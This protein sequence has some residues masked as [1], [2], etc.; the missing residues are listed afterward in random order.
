MSKTSIDSPSVSIVIPAYNEEE[1]IKIVLSD[2]IPLAEK[3]NWEIVVVDDFSS[4]ETSAAVEVFKKKYNQLQLIRN[5]YNKGYGGSLKAGIAASKSEIIV[6]MDAD[7]QHRPEDI[8]KVTNDAGMNSMVVGMRDGKSYQ[9]QLRKPGKMVLTWVA[10]FLVEQDIPDLNSGLRA[11]HKENFKEFSHLL[12]NSFSFSTTITMSFYKAGYNVRYVP[13]SVRK[14]E[15]EKSTVKFLK[16]GGQTFLLILRIVML[17]NPL[18]IF[19]PIS[20]FLFSTGF[21]YGLFYVIKD[22]D[23]PTGAELCILSSLIIFTLGLLA[24]QISSLRREKN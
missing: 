15:G 19:A 21:L 10:C 3:R 16:H 22:L 14:R 2:L 12:P 17:F 24:D 20:A 1:G 18:K 4:D 9:V 13:I 11:F 8:L 5:I 23:I 6:T 7:G